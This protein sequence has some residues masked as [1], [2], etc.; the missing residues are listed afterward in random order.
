MNSHMLSAQ[1]QVLRVHD[2][3]GGYLM[4]LSELPDWVDGY[5]FH[6]CC[7]WC[8]SLSSSM[9]HVMGFIHLISERLVFI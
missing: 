4:A 2:F 7:E 9:L 8:G 1:I 5:D 6:A 3:D